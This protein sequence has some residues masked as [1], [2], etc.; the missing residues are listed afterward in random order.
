MKKSQNNFQRSLLLSFQTIGYGILFEP[1]FL[2][3]NMALLGGIL[4]LLAESQT[5]QGRSL[6]AGLPSMGEN[7][8]REYMQFGGR[9]LLLLMFLTLIRFEV[10]VI[11]MI[12]TVGGLVLM[13]LVAI[14]YK[15]KLCSLV[16]VVWLFAMNVY[17]NAFWQFSVQKAIFD[18][19]KY[20]FFQTCSVIGGL[21]MLIALGPGGVSFDERK[22]NW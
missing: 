18:Y 22:K 10:S 16:L 2:M 5:E 15:T 7:K 9:V 11:H 14:G 20:D 1:Y 3:R 8:K 17:Y 4:L 6:F 19:L 21:L 13:M 12:Q